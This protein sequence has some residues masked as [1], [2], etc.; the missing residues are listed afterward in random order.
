MNLDQRLM[1][2]T[3]WNAAFATLLVFV[4]TSIAL[5]QENPY[6]ENYFRML[7][8]RGIATDADGL[9]SFL[10]SHIPGPEDETRL[11]QNL[12]DLGDAEYARREAAMQTL[13]A[14]PPRALEELE[15]LV[16]SDD[17]EIRWRA[18]LI[19]DSLRQ[20]GNDLLY[21]SL[22]VISSRKIQGLANVVLGVAPLCQSESM[23]LAMSRALIATATE[24]DA[25]VLRKNLASDE[26]RIRMACLNALLTAI[27]EAAVPDVVPLLDDKSDLVRFDAAFQLLKHRR[28]ESLRTLGKL[29]VSE[30]LTVR[31]R[32][33][34][35]L[36][37]TLPVS[38]PYSGYEPPEDRAR[39]AAEW[40]KT[41][42][43]NLEE[44]PEPVTITA[45]ATF[46]PHLALH[47]SRLRSLILIGRDGSVRTKEMDRAG[48]RVTV[49]ENGNLLT[50]N[51]AQPFV[52]EVDAAGKTVSQSKTLDERPI[53]AVRRN[54]GSTLVATME[55]SLIEL[56]ASGDMIR[57]TV[58]GVLLDLETLPSGDT[59]LLSFADS[60]V[61]Q[62]DV[63]GRPQ[64]QATL[65][66]PPTSMCLT[67]DGHALIALQG[68][69]QIIDVDLTTKELKPLDSP[70]R[71]PAQIE[72]LVDG[73]LVIV[74]AVG[75][76]YA[77]RQG[78]LIETIKLFPAPAGAF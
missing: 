38:L 25:E 42:E 5:A 8:E 7:T 40:Q 50:V 66:A 69:K 11:K 48:T 23:Q 46:T 65:P 45:P 1:R 34:H 64:W 71:A 13:L 73:R 24:R 62:I 4:A 32:S 30:H 47:S 29:L 27:G 31:N 70:F 10:E 52:T 44:K 20:P 15:K 17:P 51:P 75:A 77:D 61:K 3:K 37:S 9:R 67:S 60:K 53:V 49:L 76:H 55:S 28:A 56:N 39:H 74:D 21:A 68:L 54:D 78:V 26:A 18:K 59:L 12:A 57:K 16:G 22:I 58:V 43:A 33:I 36:R 14:R 19:L 35:Q 6:A 41:I 2:F 72:Q 63:T